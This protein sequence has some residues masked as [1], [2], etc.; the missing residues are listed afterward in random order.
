M[1]LHLN[2]PALPGAA[3]GTSHTDRDHA[4]HAYHRTLNAWR[5]DKNRMQFAQYLRTVAR[6]Q[7]EFAEADRAVKRDTATLEVSAAEMQDALTALKA[8][9]GGDRS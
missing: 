2:T 1:T 9:C 6:S 5:S 8:V 4:A 7:E 3:F